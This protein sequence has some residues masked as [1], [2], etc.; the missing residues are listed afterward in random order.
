MILLKIVLCSLGM[1]VIALILAFI[2]FEL[3]LSNKNKLISKD[4]TKYFLKR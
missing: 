2:F 1:I 4:I 3:K